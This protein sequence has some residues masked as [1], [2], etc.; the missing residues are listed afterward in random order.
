[1]PLRLSFSKLKLCGE[2]HST[3][4]VTL[5]STKR[6][7]VRT[8]SHFL[9]F[10]LSIPEAS[11]PLIQ[12]ERHSLSRSTLD[13]QFL[14]PKE[15]SNRLVSFNKKADIQLRNSAPAMSPVIEMLADTVAT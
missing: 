8:A 3:V 2:S 11:L 1:L 15:L 14:E 13:L 9:D 10:G 4:E 6:E 7:D 12:R 5:A